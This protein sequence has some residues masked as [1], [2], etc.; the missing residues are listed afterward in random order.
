MKFTTL[1]PTHLND[2]T[3]VEVTRL[4]GFVSR[5]AAL[6]GGCTTVGPISGVWYDQGRAFEDESILVWCVCDNDQFA[7]AE[8]AVI[9]IGR[10]LGQS[11]MYFEVRDFDG[12]RIL[13]VPPQ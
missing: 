11:A 9:D 12:V 5:L 10:E 6:F 3:P 1:I 4:Q 7:E 13:E 8:Q 2:G